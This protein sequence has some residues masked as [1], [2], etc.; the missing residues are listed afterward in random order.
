MSKS[1]SI[2]ITT[3]SKGKTGSRI[4]E[5][6]LAARLAACVQVC[7]IRSSYTWKGKV[8]EARESLMLIKARSSDFERIKAV[9]LRH[10]DYEV[11][12]IVSVRIA[13]GSAR[14]LAWIG[15]VTK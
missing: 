7:P 1:Y 11:P 9:I 8:V 2:V 13:R 4:T 15:S 5:A 3:Y 14:Y 10:H 6:L 12:E